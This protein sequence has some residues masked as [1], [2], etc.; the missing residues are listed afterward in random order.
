MNGKI[1]NWIIGLVIIEVL[2]MS[3]CVTGPA[4][5]LQTT[6]GFVPKKVYQISYDQMWDKVV[7]VLKNNGIDLS[8]PPPTKE[9][10]T[11]LTQLTEGWSVDVPAVS[12]ETYVFRYYIAFRKVNPQQT[13]VDITCDILVKKIMKGG[14][15]V[16][17]VQQLR[18]FARTKRGEEN[19][20]LELWLY[21]QIEKSLSSK[22]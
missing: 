22:K 20:R 9:S 16:E 17:A 1:G 13:Q 5:K 4:T 10:M 11:I 12:T 19:I 8:F 18:P 2:F 3:G 15:A 14:N 7:S 6:P 21:E